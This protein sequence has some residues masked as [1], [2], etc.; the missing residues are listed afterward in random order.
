MRYGGET[1]AI[2][3]LEVYRRRDDES[4]DEVD[5]RRFANSV[6]VSVAKNKRPPSKRGEV[7][8]YIH[9]ENGSIR[10]LRDED[11]LTFGVPVTTAEDAYRIA[12]Q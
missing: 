1:E 12:K 11:M 3:V 7:D 10:P 8:L 9:P 2:M 6:T 4:L 5:R